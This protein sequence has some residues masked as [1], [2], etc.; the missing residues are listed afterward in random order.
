MLS[1]TLPYIHQNLMQSEYTTKLKH[2]LMMLLDM[3]R[4]NHSLVF[5][6]TGVLKICS[7]V[8]GEHPCRSAISM[9]LL[10]NFIEIALRRGCS[11]V[12]LLHIFRISF[13]K[14]TYGRAAC[15]VQKD[16]QAGSFRDI[17]RALDRLSLD[18]III[19]LH[20]QGFDMHH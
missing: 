9:K 10:C 17:P 5:L 12:N 20:I 13:Y 3:Y 11:L 16:D 4:S 1:I 2:F 7:T 15:V 18:S 6:G 14:N 19:K 8:T